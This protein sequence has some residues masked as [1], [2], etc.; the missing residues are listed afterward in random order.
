[1]EF[2]FEKL[3]AKHYPL[4]KPYFLLRPTMCCEGQFENQY[5]WKDYYGTQFCLFDKGLLWLQNIYKRPATMMPLCKPEDLKEGFDLIQDYFDHVLHAKLEMYLVDEDALAI[6]NLDESLYEITE[7][8]ES[9]DYLYDGDKLRTLSGKKY[10]KKKNHLNS[11][12]KEYDGRYEYKKLTCEQT[13][14]VMDFLKRWKDA[15]DS[16]DEFNRL[17]N[18]SL[19]I[20]NL[21][22]NCPILRTKMAGVYIDGVL[23]SFTAGSYNEAKELAVIHLEKASEEFRG[24]YPFINQQFLLHEF[25]EAKFVNREDDMGLESLRKAKESYRPIDLIKKYKITQK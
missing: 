16:E 2:K 20:K 23:Q 22:D 12:L 10:H 24:L 3:K 4:V 17:D 25:P 6:L 7:D 8:R 9:F 15:K 1:M 11:F 5:I 18:E 21:L 19:G 13:D 14:E